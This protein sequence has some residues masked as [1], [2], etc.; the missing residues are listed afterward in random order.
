MTLF[1]VQKRP[2]IRVESDAV[3]HR[4]VSCRLRASSRGK[5]LT[6]TT[7]GT[8]LNETMNETSVVF[9]LLPEAASLQDLV[10]CD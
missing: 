3:K 5:V 2:N 4:T 10:A 8:I 6:G 7:E 9:S 1:I